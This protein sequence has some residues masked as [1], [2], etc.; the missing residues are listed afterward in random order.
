MYGTL[1]TIS[2]YPFSARYPYK[3]DKTPLQYI[4]GRRLRQPLDESALL[5]SETRLQINQSFDHD[6]LVYIPEV[7]VAE[8]L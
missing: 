5:G 2:S 6:P 3:K 1:R 8:K 7:R 4:L